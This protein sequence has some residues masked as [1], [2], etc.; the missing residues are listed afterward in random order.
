VCW[1]SLTRSNNGMP[2][3]SRHLGWVS[4]ESTN[5]PAR[6]SRSLEG[7]IRCCLL[8][9]L[10]YNVGPHRTRL[11]RVLFSS[12][13]THCSLCTLLAEVWPRTYGDMAVGWGRPLSA[14][15]LI[16]GFLVFTFFILWRLD[17][18]F[19]IVNAFFYN[20]CTKYKAKGNSL[21]PPR[22]WASREGS[23]GVFAFYFRCVRFYI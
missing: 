9:P 2:P 20:E 18:S 13:C 21:K 10:L 7:H 23:E 8:A 11:V 5:S 15:L 12:I 19:Y 4:R 1:P 3:S 22:P 16:P 6:L 17:P 14:L